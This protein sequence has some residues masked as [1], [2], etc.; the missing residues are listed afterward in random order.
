MT[1]SLLTIDDIAAMWG[2]T[3]RH[4]RDVLVKQPGF[5]PLA[6]GASARIK[7]WARREIEAYINR[8]PAQ[9]PPTTQDAAEPH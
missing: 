2:V 8:Q 5:P 9:I 3:R 4:A 6:P 1:P 7:R